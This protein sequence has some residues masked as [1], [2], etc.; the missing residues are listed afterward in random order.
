[1]SIVAKSN[2]SDFTPA[3]EG[4]WPACCCDVVDLGMVTSQWGE[5]HQI[6]LRWQLEDSDPKS[7][8]PYMVVMRARLSLHEKSKLRP[9]L[10]AWRGKKFTQEEL[11]GFDLEKLLGANCQIQ[12][13]HNIQSGGAVYA[14]VQAIVPPARGAKKLVPRDYIRV[15]DRDDQQAPAEEGREE[16][17]AATP[18]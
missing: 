8:K 11:E 10:E 12:V 5:S 16:Q 7:A 6:Q 18:F 4:L 17:E 1:M 3:P 2:K 9:M 15:Q 14:N 13:I